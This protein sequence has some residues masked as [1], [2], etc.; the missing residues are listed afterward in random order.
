MQRSVSE[1]KHVGNV[2]V[3]HES[4][5]DSSE[6][7][8]KAQDPIRVLTF[9]SPKRV[10]WQFIPQPSL[11]PRLSA[12]VPTCCYT[13]H[14]SCCHAR[15]LYT[16]LGSL[17]DAKSFDSR[18]GKT[19]HASSHAHTIHRAVTLLAHQLINMTGGSFMADM[20]ATSCEPPLQANLQ[21]SKLHIDQHHS[22]RHKEQPCSARVHARHCHPP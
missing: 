11:K 2:S 21:A 12:N 15:T 17:L 14:W 9:L 18:D 13:C 5:P 4:V 8:C 1:G 16:T 6:S 19:L 7:A 20:Q 10:C 22:S 3:V